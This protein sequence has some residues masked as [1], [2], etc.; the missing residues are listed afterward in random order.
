MSNIK[1]NALLQSKNPGDTWQCILSPERYKF[2]TLEYEWPDSFN[3][4]F[5]VDLRAVRV[6]GT[7][8]E[9]PTVETYSR[10]NR[11]FLDCGIDILSGFV[12]TSTKKLVS[13]II[14]V[15]G[16]TEVNSALRELSKTHEID[17]W[18]VKMIEIY[19]PKHQALTKFTLHNPDSNG[20][21]LYLWSVNI[22]KKEVLYPEIGLFDQQLYCGKFQYQFAHCA[23]DEITVKAH[24][25]AIKKNAKAAGIIRIKRKRPTVGATA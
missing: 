22:V 7:G 25:C 8:K 14:R 23:C 17:S 3:K 6:F 15:D 9:K 1:L 24:A 12:S 16:V 2:W 10:K 20:T 19:N 11:L 13:L 4:N 18:Q 5:G 21:D